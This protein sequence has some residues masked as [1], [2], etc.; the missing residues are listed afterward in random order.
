MADSDV[1]VLS[2]SGWVHTPECPSIRHRVE[3]HPEPPAQAGMEYE[4][5]GQ[6]DEGRRIIAEF[7]GAEPTTYYS[8]NYVTAEDI[9]SRTTKYTRCRVCAPDVPEFQP[10]LR[11]VTKPAGSLLRTDLGRPGVEGIPTSILHT[12]DMVT[13]TYDTGHARELAPDD[14]VAF[15]DRRSLEKVRNSA[16]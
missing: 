8:A 4:A 2:N 3:G 13:I 7:R 10:S 12:T 5:L 15:Y 9:A 6:D 14:E 1:F 11:V 16:P